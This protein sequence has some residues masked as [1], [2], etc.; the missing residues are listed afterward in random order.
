MVRRKP[1]PETG[2]KHYRYFTTV[3]SPTVYNN[4][5]DHF[6]VAIGAY[7]AIA[8]VEIL[9]TDAAN[10]KLDSVKWSRV[11]SF[12]QGATP[13][14]V[15]SQLNADIIGTGG[16]LRHMLVPP[17]GSIGPVQNAPGTFQL[18]ECDSIDSAMA[19]L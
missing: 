4:S 13:T 10:N 5:G 9:V 3:N 6:V 12:T 2:S 11:A 8:E 15:A 7:W 17:G 1:R 18:V 14:P 19:I 16:L